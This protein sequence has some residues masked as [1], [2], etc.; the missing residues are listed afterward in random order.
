[1]CSETDSNNGLK[2][3]ISAIPFYF[4][5]KLIAKYLGHFRFDQIP[6]IDS[7]SSVKTENTVNF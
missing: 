2:K 3:N 1:M 7:Y 6:S 4:T 5:A